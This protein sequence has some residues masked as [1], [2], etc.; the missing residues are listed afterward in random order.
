[1]ED[2]VEVVNE[3][4]RKDSSDERHLIDERMTE[5]EHG[6]II[7]TL[8]EVLKLDI[9]A[10]IEDADAKVIVKNNS[11]IALVSFTNSSSGTIDAVKLNSRG[12]NAFDDE[13]RVNG[14][15]RF[16]AVIQ[17]LNVPAG[18]RVEGVRIE[19]PNNEIRRLDIE[20]LQVRL[21]D[22]HV[23]SYAGPDIREFA[24]QRVD[25]AETGP[26]LMDALYWKYGRSFAYLPMELDEGWIC[27]CGRLNEASR[28]E[29]AYCRAS[30]DR[31]MQLLASD[32]PAKL[33]DEYA[34]H[35]IRE[36]E[37]AREA[38]AARK[39]AKTAKRRKRIIAALVIAIVA[40]AAFFAIRYAGRM[41]F[42]SVSEMKSTVQGTY[43]Q[44]G[45]NYPF[46]LKVWGDNLYWS[47]DDD[48]EPSKY[49]INSYDPT[50][51]TARTSGGQEVEVTSTG[52]LIFMGDEYKK[53]GSWP[54]SSSSSSSSTTKSY[55]SA[56]TALSMRGYLRSNSGYTTLEG[57][58][59]NSGS[60][61]YRYVQVKGSFKDKDGV[62][63]DTDWT[64]AVGSEGL[65]P[66]ESKTFRLSVKKNYSIKDCSLSIIDYS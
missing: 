33:L 12:Y 23:L 1:M 43:T 13:V 51:G 58:I 16:A 15:A 50:W 22:G 57:T 64:Y 19:L 41:H 48:R 35:R 47:F 10:H 62:V 63:V 30:E 56:Y 34:R 52:S 9:N 45:S 37:A 6:E 53:G 60:K 25:V 4:V 44:V 66:G 59:T 28:D 49:S 29:C 46:H 26:E 17:D 20:E 40:I 42:L 36:A 14:S 55:E 38:D 65:S 8:P 39:A 32:A 3:M 5:S 27:S 24:I 54:A 21:V 2:S 18:G 7:A 31:V 61:T 11:A